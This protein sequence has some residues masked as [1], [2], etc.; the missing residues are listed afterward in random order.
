MSFFNSSLRLNLGGLFDG[1]P[2]DAV[3]IVPNGTAQVDATIPARNGIAGQAPLTDP[4]VRIVPGSIRSDA[5]AAAAAR[6]YGAAPAS[7]ATAGAVGFFAGIKGWIASNP[8]LAVG[9]AG[10]LLLTFGALRRKA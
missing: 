9:I 2:T 3:T 5:P 10:L 7:G 6:D 1:N 4:A 8:L